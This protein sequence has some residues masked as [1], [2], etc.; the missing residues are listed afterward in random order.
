M[1]PT[2]IAIP[3]KT[4][5]WLIKTRG[6]AD[7]LA[8]C[9]QSENVSILEAYDFAEGPVRLVSDNSHGLIVIWNL[10]YH[11]HYGETRSGLYVCPNH[12][13][14]SR[15]PNRRLLHRFHVKSM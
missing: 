2:Y 1:L 13:A 15:V 10:D 14:P 5:E 6:I 7:E 4:A 12:S 11:V 9:L 3:Q 8:R